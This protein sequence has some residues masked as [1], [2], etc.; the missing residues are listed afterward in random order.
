MKTRSKI[1]FAGLAFI[2]LSC[3]FPPWVNVLDIPY[4]AHQ[5]TPAGYEFILTPPE[6]LGGRWSIQIDMNVL[7]V[8]WIA[9]AALTGVIWLVVV[10][11]PWS[12]DDKENRPQKIILPSNLNN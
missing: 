1:V 10:K 2:V 11:P 3:L 6:P 5:R 9:V 8:E 12:R 4:H 7:F